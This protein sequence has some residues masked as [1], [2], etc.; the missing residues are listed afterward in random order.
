MPFRALRKFE[1]LF[2][3]GPYLHRNSTLGDSVALEVYEDLFEANR[4]NLYYTRVLEQS[5]V[6]NISNVR[7]GV[8]AR[9][10][11]GTFGELNLNA[12]AGMH[13]GYNV[14]RGEV[15][16]IEVGIEVKILAK[17]MIKQIGRVVSD[18]RHQ[19][20][21]FRQRGGTKAICVGIAGV[22][23]AKQYLSYEKDRKY[24]T[25]I[26]GN[27]NPIQEAPRAAERLIR[28]C[29]PDFDEFI[30]LKFSATNAEPFDFDWINQIETEQ[31]YGAALI[32]VSRLYDDRFLR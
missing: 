27:P 30:I 18:F 5:S 13:S 19:V 2:T 28:E 12:K 11:D 7:R 22:N 23:F 29:A 8:P 1:R 32:R 14:S 20:E 6:V 3:D 4:S 10:G 16:T 9:R 31:Q 26:D 21:H 15:A 17:A 25:G 24:L